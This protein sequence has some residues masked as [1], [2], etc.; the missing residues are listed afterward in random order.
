MLPASTA[1]A[2]APTLYDFEK[3]A[4]GWT[5]IDAWDKHIP[6]QVAPAPA[7]DRFASRGKALKVP[8][9]FPGAITLCSA[10]PRDWSHVSAITYDIYLPPAATH[11]QLAAYAK[12]LDL[13][14]YQTNTL[15]SPQPGQ[16]TTVRL[17]VSPASRLWTGIGHHRPWS[18]YVS[19]GIQEFG[20]KLFGKHSWKGVAYIDNIRAEPA[21]KDQAGPVLLLNFRTNAAR[22]KRYGKFEITFELPRACDNP[23]D[24]DIIDIRAHFICSGTSVTKTVP[25]FVYQDYMRRIERNVERLIPIGRTVWK[26]RF[27]PPEEGEYKY[28]IEIFEKKKLILRTRK[29]RF[30]CSP[31]N[32]RGFLRVSERDPHYFEFDNG[33]F[34]Y[35][36]GHNIPAT[37]NIKNAANLGLQLRRHEGTFAY[38]RFLNGMGRAGENFARIW[39]ASW[40]FAIEWTRRYD[41]RYRD[42]GRYNLANAWKLDYVLD[43][44]ARNGVYVQ[45]ALT[46]F[47]HWRSQTFEGDW[48]YNPYNKANRGFLDQP[49]EFW[50]SKRGQQLYR[51]RLRYIMARWGYATQIASWEI[52]N[53]INLVTGYGK[54]KPKIVAW[55]RDVVKAIRGH[56]Q[57]RHLIT[58]NFSVWSLDPTILRLPEIS[59]SST[60][61][62]HRQIVGRLKSVCRRKCAYRKPAIMTEC[63]DDFKGSSPEATRRYI[64]ICLWS[65]YM[66]PFAG[67]GMAW[68]WG[69]I[70]DRDLYHLFTPLVEFARGEDRRGKNLRMG[71]ARALTRSGATLEALGVEYLHGDRTGYFWVYERELLSADLQA[72]LPLRRNAAIELTGLAKGAYRVEFW[73][74]VKGKPIGQENVRSSTGTVLVP[75]PA[76]TDHLAAKVKP[77]SEP[78]PPVLLNALTSPD[79]ESR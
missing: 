10:A 61:H 41:V 72:Q 11:V 77:V 38:D 48:P 20:I 19:Q 39:M 68:W 32:N 27:A 78:T 37:F 2:A 46:T 28:Y 66:M 33:D 69:F 70:D 73:D 9:T 36:I 31:S 3:D 65:S 7:D 52:C 35:P 60:N 14:W 23:F 64:R 63:G 16:W 58:T 43:L 79:E 8:L 21:P 49:T 13:L 5:Y 75:L 1:A 4:A 74:T 62:Y 12:D 24:P 51:R 44:A 67:A 54:V 22:V 50:T 59:Y 17:D 34:F 29:R 15:A 53:E 40:S 26:V 56:D 30:L 18:G 76:F 6:A 55:H 25:A 47:G 57:G 45:L 71:T 42:I